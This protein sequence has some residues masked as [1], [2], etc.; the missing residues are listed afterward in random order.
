MPFGLTN[1][2]ATVQRFM[3]DTLREHLDQFCIVYIDDILIYF[4][5]LKDHKKHVRHVLNKLQDAGLFIKPEKYEF[6]IQ[7]TTFLGFVISSEG[8]EMDPTKI[9]TITEWETPRN[10]KDIQCFLGFANFYQFFIKD[11]SRLYQLLF[12]LLKNDVPFV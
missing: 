8:I 12:Y 3:N 4:K 11:Y 9:N 7:K 10:V 2:P 6:S 1:T 5:N